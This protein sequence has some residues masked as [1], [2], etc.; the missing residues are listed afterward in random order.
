MEETAWEDEESGEGVSTANVA[1][2]LDDEASEPTDATEDRDG[3]FCGVWF[4]LL[5]QGLWF[6]VWIGNKIWLSWR[7]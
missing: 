4:F 7:N 5:G 2:S 3:Y 6:L 1:S